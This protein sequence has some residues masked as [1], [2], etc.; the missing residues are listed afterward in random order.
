MSFLGYPKVIPYTKFEQFV[1]ELY[2]KQTN[3]QT[4]GLIDSVGVG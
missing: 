2:S 3:K 1:F 4:D